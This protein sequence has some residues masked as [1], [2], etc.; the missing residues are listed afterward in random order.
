MYAEETITGI[1]LSRLSHVKFECGMFVM[2]RSDEGVK[3][4]R[5]AKSYRQVLLSGYI[6]LVVSALKAEGPGFE[7]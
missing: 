3:S 6:K 5:M 2:S 7:S 1:N 4:S